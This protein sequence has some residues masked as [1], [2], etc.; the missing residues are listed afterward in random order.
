MQKQV[1]AATMYVQELGN[2]FA[3]AQSI[4]EVKQEVI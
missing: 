1:Q 3:K 4:D 2:T